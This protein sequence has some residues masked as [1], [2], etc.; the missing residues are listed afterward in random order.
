MFFSVF[1]TTSVLIHLN[2]P[3]KILK[4]KAKLSGT[5]MAQA[6]PIMIILFFMFR[7]N[8]GGIFRVCKAG[9][10]HLGIIRYHFTGKHIRACSQ[11]G[12]LLSGSN[13]FTGLCPAPWIHTISSTRPLCSSLLVHSRPRRA[14][15]GHCR[16]QTASVSQ[17]S[18]ISGPLTRQVDQRFR[19]NHN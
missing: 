19:N 16:Q 9:R 11:P 17:N 15:H 18:S 6:I 2:S 3:G 1:L 4:D 13:T 12:S 5:M 14:H 10:R 7:Q 8:P